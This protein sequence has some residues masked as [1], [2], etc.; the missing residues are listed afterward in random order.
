MGFFKQLLAELL[1]GEC[2]YLLI[3]YLV[4]QYMITVAETLTAVMD[5]THFPNYCIKA[6]LL[7]VKNYV[8]V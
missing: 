4:M 3:R 8:F 7:P 6:S 1:D 2:R 5:Q